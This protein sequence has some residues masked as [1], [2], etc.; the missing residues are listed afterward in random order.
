MTRHLVYGRKIQRP[1]QQVHEMHAKIYETPTAGE[2]AVKAPR[3][4]R[5]V[6]IVKLKLR[7]KYLAQIPAS[8]QIT[9][10]SRAIDISIREIDHQQLVRTLCSQYDLL[11]LAR[12][13][14]KR[15]L[16]KDGN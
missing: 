16:A 2:F 13:T 9:Y 8:H 7:R 3:L 15:L 4:V 14:A 10:R 12:S 5:S 1:Q 11:N 6:G